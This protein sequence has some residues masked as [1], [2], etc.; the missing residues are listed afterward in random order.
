MTS[1]VF[2]KQPV[3]Y[4]SSQVVGQSNLNDCYRLLLL[5]LVTSQR[6]NMSPYF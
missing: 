4:T 2:L 3:H 6:L 1:R 5:P